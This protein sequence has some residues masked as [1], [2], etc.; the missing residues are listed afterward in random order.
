MF[1]LFEEIRKDMTYDE[2]QGLVARR[3]RK[4]QP[5]CCCGALYGNTHHIGCDLERC[6]GCGEQFFG[7]GCDPREYLTDVNS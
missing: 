6:M 1:E 7:C 5:P 4:D 3:Y 2:W